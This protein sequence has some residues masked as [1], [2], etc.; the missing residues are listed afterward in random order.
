MQWG[1]YG[2]LA[3]LLIGVLVGWMFAGFVGAFVR[4]AIFLA[5]IIP[6]VL[7]FL[8]WRKFI[9]PWLRP[10]I[11]RTYDDPVGAIDAIETRAVVQQQSVREPLTR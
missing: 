9:A 2:F 6:I 8:A 10:P 11:E 1:G 3:G 7:V 4:V 5:A